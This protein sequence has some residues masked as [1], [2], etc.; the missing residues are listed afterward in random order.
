[1]HN[2]KEGKDERK[3]C[4]PGK[5]ICI[6]AKGMLIALYGTSTYTYLPEK[7][8]VSLKYSRDFLFALFFPTFRSLQFPSPHT[9]FT[10]DKKNISH[11]RITRGHY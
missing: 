9:V 6:S 5:K 3:Y 10:R 1:M 7:Y 11:S 8:L 2:I 4:R